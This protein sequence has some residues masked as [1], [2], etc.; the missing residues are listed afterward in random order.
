MFRYREINTV[1]ELKKILE[2]FNDSDIIKVKQDKELFG[3][4]IITGVKQSTKE[5]VIVFCPQYTMKE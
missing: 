2:D 4:E 1:G 5:K 3:A